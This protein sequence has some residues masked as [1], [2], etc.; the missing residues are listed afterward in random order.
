MCNNTQSLK[1]EDNEMRTESIFN[2]FNRN[3]RLTELKKKE[4]KL[5]W[6]ENNN[7]KRIPCIPHT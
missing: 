3:K 6:L 5:G 2:Y 7:N 4:K 1:Q